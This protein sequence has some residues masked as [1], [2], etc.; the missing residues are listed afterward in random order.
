ME[1]TRKLIMR[2]EHPT[3]CD[4]CLTDCVR[5]EIAAKEDEIRTELL[6]AC[7][8]IWWYEDELYDEILE[9]DLGSIKTSGLCDALKQDNDAIEKAKP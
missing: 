4:L 3:P 5:A 1:R 7:K 6:D 9:G 2:C 8:A